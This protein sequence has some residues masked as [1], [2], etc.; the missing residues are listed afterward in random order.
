MADVLSQSQIDALLQSMQSVEEESI[1]EKPKE[2]QQKYRK[3][4]FYSPKKYTKDK[5]KMLRSIYDNYC[6]IATSQINGL[7]RVA[8]EVEVVGV[9]EQRYYEFGNALNESD[10]ISL[11]RVNLSDHSKNPPMLFHIA[12]TLMG[13]MIDR[14]L[15]GTGTDTSVDMSYTYTDIELALYE[16]IIQY[17]VAITPDVW[18]SYIKLKTEFE[19]VEENPSMFQGISVDETVVIVMINISIGDVKG[20]MN[21]CIP[22][23]LL[24]NIFDII[25]KTKHLADK[26]GVEDTTDSRDEILG[27]IKES[28]IDVMAQLGVM[29][30]N[31]DDVYN[32]H[33][34]DVINMNK[35]QDSEVSLYVAGQPWFQGQL[36]VYNKNIAV[37]IEDRV[38]RPGSETA[39]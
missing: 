33:V 6:R 25:E 28:K 20:A 30:L 4:D 36:G 23:T 38:E 12:P 39:G 34:G 17:L 32:L 19:R 16:R 9:E 3:Y 35:P 10:V 2:P 7:F 21:I 15:G 13:A 11:V 14:M 26:G 5:L 22:G 24:G 37:K 18:S 27:S 1:A 31:L 29:Q 8:S